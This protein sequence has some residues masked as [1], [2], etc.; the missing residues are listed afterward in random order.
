MTNLSYSIEDNIKKSQKDGWT[1]AN[2]KNDA[3][4]AAI[5]QYTSLSK[6]QVRQY[7]HHNMEALAAFQKRK[8]AGMNLS[9]KVWRMTEQFKG[10]LEM[11]LDQGIGEGQSATQ[12]QKT[13]RKYL[14]NGKDGTNK[15]FRRV[16]DKH[17]NLVLSKNAKNYHPGAGIYRSSYKNAMRLATTENNAAYRTADHARQVRLDFI[18]GIEIRLSNNHTINGKPFVDMCDELVG[19]YPVEF[20][21][22]GW[23]PHCRCWT[24]TIL[25]TISQLMAHKE[26]AP[27]PGKIN[28]V[29]D[30]F[31]NYIQSNMDRILDS[32]NKGTV[33]Y[34]IKNNEAIT[35]AIMNGNPTDHI[36]KSMRP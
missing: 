30:S 20:M 16:R 10:E 18:L 12:L 29:P 23:H 34:F 5:M 28:D 15:L 33:P 3:L 1:Y 9:E 25:P 6:D 14:V 8:I 11:A 4:V 31:K 27:W 21:F 13:L 17:G 32:Q 22:T 2:D 24:I 7:S 19:I 36:I 35:D 26:G